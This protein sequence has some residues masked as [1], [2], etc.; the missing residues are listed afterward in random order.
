MESDLQVISLVHAWMLNPEM[1]NE[2]VDCENGEQSE[3]S[4]REPLLTH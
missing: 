4:A 1:K 2:R 3:V